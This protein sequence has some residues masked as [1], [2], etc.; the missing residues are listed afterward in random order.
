[1]WS[2]ARDVDLK[3]KIKKKL[4]SLYGQAVKLILPDRSLSTKRKPEK[5]EIIPS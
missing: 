4:D 5:L 2:K 1:M 3:N